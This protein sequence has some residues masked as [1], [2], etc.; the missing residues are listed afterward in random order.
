MKRSLISAAGLAAVSL[1]ISAVG[2]VTQASAATCVE[3]TKWT[4]PTLSAS[5]KMDATANCDGLY[6]LWTDVSADY[7][8]ARYY[9]DG[10][11]QTGDKGYVWIT[12]GQG[13]KIL[14]DTV[15]GRDLKGQSANF[16][17]YVMY[18]Y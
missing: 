10:A 17:Q 2:P 5:T 6:A 8:R 18:G 9:K 11:W 14:G 15:T 4:S 13:A 12:P 7:I 16:Q 1:I 3:G